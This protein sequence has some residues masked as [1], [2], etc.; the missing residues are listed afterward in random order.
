MRAQVLAL[1]AAG[2]AV[3]PGCLCVREPPPPPAAATATTPPPPDAPRGSSGPG[4]RKPTQADLLAAQ[5]ANLPTSF[6]EC[7]R[8]PGTRTAVWSCGYRQETH[9]AH[10][11]N[12]RPCA[13]LLGIAPEDPYGVGQCGLIFWDKT[14]KLPTSWDDCRQRFADEPGINQ[15]RGQELCLVF[16]SILDAP[17]FAEC[18]KR[19][20]HEYK[21]G[22][23]RYPLAGPNWSPRQK[24]LADEPH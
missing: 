17:L 21:D 23:C 16:V 7:Q 11:P 10:D 3:A 24:S 18:S 14:V 13:P 2:A 4:Y 9:V 5:G 12:L 15:P 20:F 19:P 8:I 22:F 1:A 6:E